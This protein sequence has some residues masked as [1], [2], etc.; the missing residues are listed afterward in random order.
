VRLLEGLG[1][2][3]LGKFVPSA[4]A[5]SAIAGSFRVFIA[6][7]RW[8]DPFPKLRAEG[9]GVQAIMSGPSKSVF[10]H[11]Q[12]RRARWILDLEPCSAAPVLIGGGMPK[13]VSRCR[14]CPRLAS[15]G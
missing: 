8:S 13:G 7:L 4:E 12:H 3:L 1:V 2:V 9:P 6:V 11:A 15:R 10:P 14:S 5:A